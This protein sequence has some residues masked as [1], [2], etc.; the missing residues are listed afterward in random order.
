MDNFPSNSHRTTPPLTP[1]PPVEEK[2]VQPVVTGRVIRR[3]KPL[4]KRFMETFFNGDSNGVV[5]YLVRDVLVP[6][7]QNL[8]TDMVK[9]G[10]D[11]AIYG[12]ASPQYRNARPTYGSSRSIVSYDRYAPS[13]RP[14]QATSTMRTPARPPA[15]Q[16]SAL[17]IGE[18]ILD[19]R[20]EAQETLEGL[21]NIIEQ[22]AVAS[23][24]DLNSLLSQTSQ[25]PDHKYG[26]RDISAA[27]IKPIRE[28]WLLVLPTP[29][30]LDAR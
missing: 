26:W 3:K 14:T 24:A 18:I 23:V 28:G 25:P 2:N 22:Y 12:T 5:G 6:A 8:V 7:I 27:D 16:V 9:Q 11:K 30:D 15:T 19:S 4:G 17:D 13:G 10:I 29:E 20:I 21:S 1:K